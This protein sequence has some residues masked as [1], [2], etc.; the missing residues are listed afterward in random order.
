MFCAMNV[1]IKACSNIIS[2]ACKSASMYI[3]PGT[4]PTHANF[5]LQIL[6][7]VISLFACTY[8][9]IHKFSPWFFNPIYYL[10]LYFLL[11][12]VIKSDQDSLSLLTLE[13]RTRGCHLAKRHPFISS[14]AF[15]KC[16]SFGRKPNFSQVLDHF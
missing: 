4:A 3:N 8:L 10:C 9:S 15:Q 12:C 13:V 2:H 6:K 16:Y 1:F 11:K 14:R 5:T 7:G